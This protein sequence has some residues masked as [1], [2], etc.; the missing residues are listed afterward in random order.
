MKVEEIERLL[1]EF[2]EGNTTESQE[3]ILKDYFRTA[4]VPGNLHKDKEIF[5]SLYQDANQEVEV[6]A[7]LV[8]K[9]SL[10]IDKKAEEEQRFFIRNKSKRNWR[11]IGSIAA[12]VLLLIGI[13]YGTGNLDKDICSP[14]RDTFSDPEQAY[15]VLQ[16]TLMEVST[17]LNN[18]LSEVEKTQLDIITVNQEVKQEI[19]R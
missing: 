7:G 10:L 6:P 2:Y 1:A 14:P 18:G 9:L 11:W 4:E 3:E 12:T 15:R 16:A 5:L 8:D 13:G 17:N 19:Q